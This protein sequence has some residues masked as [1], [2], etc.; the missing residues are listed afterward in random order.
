[1]FCLRTQRGCT[2]Q[3]SNS[4]LSGPISALTT[5]PPRL[6]IKS[7]NPYKIIP[8]KNTQIFSEKL[9]Y[10][11]VSTDFQDH[12]S[13]SRKCQGKILY[14]NVECFPAILGYYRLSKI[15]KVSN[16][17]NHVLKK[18]SKGVP[19]FPLF[20]HRI[21]VTEKAGRYT[22]LNFARTTF[23]DKTTL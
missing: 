20:I 19:I 4:R 8:R 12:V 3:G 2:G 21:P 22:S 23:M 14:F 16:F 1:M 18:S 13:L 11:S 17:P 6:L 9:Y 7:G 5:E 15:R 10:Y